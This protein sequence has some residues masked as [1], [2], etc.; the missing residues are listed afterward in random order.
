MLPALAL[1]AEPA[2]P[3]TMRGP[4]RTG[5]LIERRLLLRV[6][7][8]LGPAEA[9]V[10]MAAFF[11]VLSLGGWALG[12]EPSTAVLAAASGAAF[13]AVVLGQLANAFVCRSE[14]RWAGRVPL[15]GNRLL[16]WAVTI[17]AIMLLVFVGFPPLARLLGGAFPPAA[18]WAM[19]ALA[20]PAVV[21]ADSVHKA[22][23]ARRR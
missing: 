23:Q 14:T 11:T 3:R 5:A 18:G 16:L 21:G 17:E 10:E 6:F 22:W 1:G 7:G 8:V 9:L 2:N 13:A 12:V 4:T 15:L 20:I 19:A